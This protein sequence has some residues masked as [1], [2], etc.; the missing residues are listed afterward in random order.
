MV[1]TWNCLRKTELVPIR[2]WQ[3]SRI[4]DSGSDAN[5]RNI[6]CIPAVRIFAFLELEKS[7][8]FQDGCEIAYP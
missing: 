2:K 8:S 7:I 6:P 4:S 3:F 5:P 1:G